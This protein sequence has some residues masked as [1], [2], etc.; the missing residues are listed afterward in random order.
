MP[1]RE[2]YSPEQCE[3]LLRVS[4]AARL[5][6]VS[7]YSTKPAKQSRLPHRLEAE[8]HSKT[9]NVIVARTRRV[10]IHTLIN[11]APAAA[12]EA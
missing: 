6:A 2:A 4:Q 1:H 3:S 7:R 9:H 8:K 11:A 10:C 5:I 12:A